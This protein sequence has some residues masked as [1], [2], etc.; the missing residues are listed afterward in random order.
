MATGI[1]ETSVQDLIVPPGGAS[2]L[3]AVGDIGGFYHSSLDVAPSQAF[4]NPTYGSTNGLDY[5]GNSPKNVVRSGASTTLPQVAL[6]GDFGVSWAADYG[7]AL[8]V[9]PG[10]VA[11]SA[12][13]DTVLLMSSTNGPLVSQYTS[14]FTAVST[15]PSGA[16]I[17]SDKRNGTVFY[18]GSAGR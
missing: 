12:N 10:K 8:T 6:S 14:T 4:R 2:L 16:V 1:E 11:L 15:L 9:G 5:A 13:G 3:S 18:G 17:A 7:A